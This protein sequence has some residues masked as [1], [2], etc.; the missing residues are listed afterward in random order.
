[1]SESCSLRLLGLPLHLPT[2]EAE[3]ITLTAVMR[4]IL[5]LQALI[6]ELYEPIIPPIPIYCD[7]QGALTLA[8]NNKFHARMKHI[9]IQYHYVR[10]L[11]WSGLLD[12]QYCPTEDNIADIFTKALPRLRLTKLRAGLGLDTAHRGVLD[13]VSS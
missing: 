5:Y 13:S 3:Y 7:N 8:T 6:V 10:S 12:L 9:D 1:L 11:V 2:A 4:E